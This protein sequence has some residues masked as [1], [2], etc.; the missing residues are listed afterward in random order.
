MVNS[1]SSQ[2]ADV[3]IEGE[4][5]SAVGTNLKVRLRWHAQCPRQVHACMH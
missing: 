3:L 4:K 5:V 1:D 2:L